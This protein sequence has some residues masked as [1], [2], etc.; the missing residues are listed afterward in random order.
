MGILDRA[1]SGMRV[2]YAARERANKVGEAVAING[3]DQ[4]ADS[5]VVVRTRFK[6]KP[7]EQ[8]AVWRIFR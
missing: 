7:L 3:V 5:A 6:A 1:R 4:S 8:W 2:M